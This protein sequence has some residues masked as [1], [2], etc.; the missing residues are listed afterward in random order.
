ML[1]KA[2]I[3]KRNVKNLVLLPT[4]LVSTR[5]PIKSESNSESLRMCVCMYVC[6]GIDPINSSNFINF[7]RFHCCHTNWRR[8]ILSSA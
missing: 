6:A 5:T 4:V 2:S 1:P 7:D 3:K 8:P